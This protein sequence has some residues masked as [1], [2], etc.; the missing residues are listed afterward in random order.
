MAA[1][2]KYITLDGVVSA[3]PAS[4]PRIDMNAAD[5][6]AVKILPLK[7][8]ISARSMQQVP[9]GG[10]TGRCRATGGVLT[11]RGTNLTDLKI[12]D[13]AGRK[14]LGM[15]SG[16]GAAGLGLP[17][18]SFTSSYTYVAA[19]YLDAVDFNST[20]ILNFISGFNISDAYTAVNLRYYGS[21]RA[22]AQS[23]SLRAAVDTAGPTVAL[24]TMSAG[25]H[26]V[27]VDYDNPL[28]KLSLAIDQTVTPTVGT[29]TTDLN[30]PSGS[31]IELGYHA[32]AEGLLHSKVGDVYTFTDSLL[33][34]DLGKEQLAALVAALKTVYG[35]V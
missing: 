27:I 17:A 20:S 28:R 5:L 2:G 21:L 25:W 7:H 11:P 4:A 18:G 22:G 14:C 15:N 9:A 3:A 24:T 35:I 34:T 6:A 32:G 16:A 29:M 1:K 8:A 23:N 33:K 31:Y 30:P 10:V 19:I 12:F 26:I 13:I